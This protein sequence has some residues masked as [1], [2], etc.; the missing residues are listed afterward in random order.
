MNYGD[1]KTNFAGLLNRRDCTPAQ[2][3]AFLQSGLGRIQRELRCPA[4]EKVVVATIA[5]GYAGLVIPS[6]MIELI[7]L[8]NS[9]GDR[10]TKEDVTTVNKLA[11]NTDV[12]RFYCREGGV[13]LIGPAP[14]IG[15]KIKLVYY[16]EIGDL[17]NPTDS[18][19]ISQIAPELVWYSGLTFAGINFTDRRRGDWEGTYT[20]IRDD[21]QNQADEDELSGGATVSPSFVY[22]DEDF[23]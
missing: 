7:R 16:A 14:L 12:P 20:Q 13:W 1:I 2:Q 17:V 5:V 6:D 19:V 11:L 8:V 9:K 22:P 21:L 4:M 18:N 15:D 10:L 23:L 3:D